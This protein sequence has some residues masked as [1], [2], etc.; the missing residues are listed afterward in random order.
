MIGDV[1]DG[2]AH[3]EACA[4]QTPGLVFHTLCMNVKDRYSRSIGSKGLG[5]AQAD[6]TCSARDDNS[7][8][9]NIEQ[10]RN[11]LGRHLL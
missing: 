2:A 9:F 10:I 11:L 8:T 7:I 5:I 6:S 4:A 3:V 1:D